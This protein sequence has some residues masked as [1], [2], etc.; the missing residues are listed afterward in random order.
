MWLCAQW[1]TISQNDSL[2]LLLYCVVS[3]L[4]CPMVLVGLLPQMDAYHLAQDCYTPKR[5][6]LSVYDRKVSR[7][8]MLNLL[9]SH[10][11]SALNLGLPC[12]SCCWIPS[13]LWQRFVVGRFDSYS[14]WSF[15]IFFHDWFTCICEAHRSF[16]KPTDW[17]LATLWASS[18]ILSRIYL[19]FSPN[20]SWTWAWVFHKENYCIEQSCKARTRATMINC[21]VPLGERFGVFKGK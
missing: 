18:P 5:E 19:F 3:M 15:D 12:W 11:L 6:I 16:H 4:Q 9:S 8:L 7:S 14:L 21:M 2:W 17:Y 1:R 10:S 13:L 20:L